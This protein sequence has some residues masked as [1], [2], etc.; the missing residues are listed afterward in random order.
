MSKAFQFFFGDNNHASLLKEVSGIYSY[1]NGDDKTFL[2]T[3]TT[4]L[5]KGQGQPDC[6]SFFVPFLS[7]KKEVNLFHFGV[8]FL[9]SPSQCLTCWEQY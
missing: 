7:S 4:F 3:T 6:H 5:F 1:Y 8:S 9:E 2:F